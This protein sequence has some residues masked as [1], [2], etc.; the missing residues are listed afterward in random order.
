MQKVIN[1]LTAIWSPSLRGS[2]LKYCL[3][4][5]RCCGQVVSLFTREWIE[6]I[7]SGSGKV[8]DDGLPLYEGVD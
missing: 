8:D 7:S 3:R 2:G 1:H 4:L 6:I 5:P